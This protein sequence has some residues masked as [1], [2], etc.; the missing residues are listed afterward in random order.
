M[1]TSTIN[2]QIPSIWKSALYPVCCGLAANGDMLFMDV[3]LLCHYIA[4]LSKSDRTARRYPY[5]Y[6]LANICSQVKH[7]PTEKPEESCQSPFG[8]FFLQYLYFLNQSLDKY[9]NYQS[10]HYKHEVIFKAFG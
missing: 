1:L 2:I 5:A 3:C 7:R 10:R 8:L 6:I 4:L 9:Y